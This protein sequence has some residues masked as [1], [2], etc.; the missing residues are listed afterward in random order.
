MLQSPIQ[1]VKA[2]LTVLTV[3]GFEDS[4][5][6]PSIVD[7]CFVRPEAIQRGPRIINEL[8]GGIQWCIPIANV[9]LNYRNGVG[10]MQGLPADVLL[11][12]HVDV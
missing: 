9:D 7:P 1:Q 12:K 2:L 6:F 5:A 11:G 10:I 3:L 8:A 4:G